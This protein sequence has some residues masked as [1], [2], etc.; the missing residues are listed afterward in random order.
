MEE[1]M[2]IVLDV[3]GGDH[4]PNEILNG[5]VEAL[6][7]DKDLELV[8]VGKID[9]IESG[10]VNA[11]RSRITIVDASDIITNDDAP[12]AAIRKKTESSLVRA[13]DYLAKNDDA[14]G[15]VSAGSTGAVLTG[16]ALK[17]KR[18]EGIVRPGLAPALPTVK[19]GNVLLIDCGA[20]VDC[21]PDTLVQFALMGSAYMSAM[22]GIANP[23]VALLNNG[24]EESKGN[25]LTKEAYKL[26]CE[27]KNINFIGNMEARELI[28]GEADVV[29]ADGFA[30]NIALKACEGTALSM[31]SL[32]KDA[33]MNSGL[34][35]KIG[36]LL[37]KKALM[38]LRSKLDYTQSGGAAF[39][40]VQKVVVKSHGSSKAPSICASILQAKRLAEAGV[41]GKIAAQLEDRE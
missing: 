5:A 37:V 34:K 7:K 18:L 25:E 17:V 30:G 26:L 41:I 3:S 22:Y 11:D 9:E 31:F 6:F 8:L 32:L 29:V 4:A 28:S 24:A 16:A 21:K 2:K 35:T 27:L 40:G 38:G 1:K 20:N 33:L 36:A 19:G 14:H 10:I 15:L 39:L 23:R 13:L 12:V